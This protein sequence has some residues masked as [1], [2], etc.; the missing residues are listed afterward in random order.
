MERYHNGAYWEGDPRPIQRV[1]NTKRNLAVAVPVLVLIL[2]WVAFTISA[3]EMVLLGTVLMFAS[4]FILVALLLWRAGNRKTVVVQ[5]IPSTHL[6]VSIDHG[7][8]PDMNDPTLQR[9]FDGSAWTSATL[10]RKLEERFHPFVR[11]NEYLPVVS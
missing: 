2:L 7:W 4:P 8:Y 5:S 3:T 6:T 1:D 9:W 10:P 11:L